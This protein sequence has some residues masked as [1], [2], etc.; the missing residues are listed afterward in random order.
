MLTA[1]GKGLAPDWKRP[2]Q[3][4]RRFRI[5]L[6]A[7]LIVGAAVATLGSIEWKAPPSPAP[8]RAVAPAPPPPAPRHVLSGRVVAPADALAVLDVP[9]GT[10]VTRVYVKPGD[11]VWKGDTLARIHEP[12]GNAY[13]ER[14]RRG[15]DGA[16]RH[17]NDVKKRYDGYLASVRAR[18]GQ[19][20]V[21]ERSARRRHATAEAQ[22][23]ALAAR[24]LRAEL[25]EARIQE[26]D[27]L[28]QAKR[29]VDLARR[30]FDDAR[31][32][33]PTDAV[34]APIDGQVIAVTVHSHEKVGKAKTVATIVNRWALQVVAD[35]DG[36]DG[37]NV[38]P[39]QVLF[40]TFEGI[41]DRRFA[42]TVRRLGLD[43]SAPLRRGLH[44]RVAFVDLPEIPA[45]V[46]PGH[47]TEVASALRKK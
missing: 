38:E 33:L 43:L 37:Q 42:G 46:M 11:R 9:A 22:R 24:E 30:T 15:L 40:V 8:T 17:Y 21:R 6:V 1:L 23:L 5:P 36:P 4:T 16:E 47:K 26:S 28:S 39:G 20:Q 3:W 14:A 31:L 27:F 32:G 12:D 18:L 29:S 34:T 25:D 44:R 10:T 45:G 2:V 13:Y 7:L 19:L 41:A 35:L